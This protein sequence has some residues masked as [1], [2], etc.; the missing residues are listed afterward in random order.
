MKAQI[1]NRFG[2]P[3]VFEL[4]DLPMPMLIPGYVLIN[5]LATSVNPIDCKIRSGSVKTIAPDF[6]AILHGDVA[7]IIVSVAEDVCDFK[8]GDE[9]Y[10]FAGGVC[11]MNGALA[12]FMLADSKLLAKKPKSLSML[13]AA[14]LPLISITAWEALFN[15]A[16][17]NNK[18]SILIHGGV[19]GVGHIAIQLAICCGAKVVTTVRKTK[20]FELVKLLGVDEIIN[21]EQEE[22]KSYVQRLTQGRGFDIV[23]DTVGGDN[24]DRSFAAIS[25]HG[26]VVTI[27]ARSKHDLSPLHNKGG[28]LH[29]VFTLLPLLTNVLRENYGKI[30]SMIANF[31]DQK[32]LKPFIDPHQFTLET[33]GAAHTLLES[34]QA[35]GKVVLSVAKHEVV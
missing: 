6:P 33:V 30:L 10:G 11:G 25:M 15:K 32:K 1:I 26:I 2:D 4:T 12:E 31:V 17:I 9:V 35:R 34:G 7:G 18:S 13:E 28:S 21:G 24:L 22:V 23:F 3:S 20:D 5:V 16:K 8:V 19:G 29:C 14:A 27:A